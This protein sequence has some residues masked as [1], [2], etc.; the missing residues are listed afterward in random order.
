MKRIRW[1]VVLLVLWLMLCLSFEWPGAPGLWAVLRRWALPTSAL[2]PLLVPGLARSNGS[3]LVG[4]VVVVWLAL[5]AVSGAGL[6]GTALPWTIAEVSAVAISVLL[7]RWLSLGLAEFEQAVTNLALGPMAERRARQGEIYREI[8]RAR[9][10][11]RPL[12]IL[13]VRHMP[14]SAKVA[15]ERLVLETQQAMLEHYLMASISRAV[16]GALA[17]YNILARRKDHFL[18]VVPEA[19]PETL[20]ETTAR[21]RRAVQEQVGVEVRIGAAL[22]PGDALTFE[23]LV[24]KALH[25]MESEGGATLVPGAAVALET[26]LVQEANHGHVDRQ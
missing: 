16:G 6:W 20:A 10:H 11:Q 19:T 3:L 14:A 12:A 4:V 9:V 5:R 21:L 15:L 22:L 25:A 24:E 18:I 2:V 1:P 13:A 8:Q 17:T 23:G 26:L 7:A